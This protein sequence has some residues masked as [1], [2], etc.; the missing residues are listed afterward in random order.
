MPKQVTGLNNTYLFALRGG[1]LKSGILG[2]LRGMHHE[3]GGVIT[4]VRCRN[5]DS[6]KIKH[7]YV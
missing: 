4:H 6:I 2:D 7:I 1:L 5:K 3:W